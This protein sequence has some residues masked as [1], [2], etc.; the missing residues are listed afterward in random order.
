MYHVIAA[1]HPQGAKNDVAIADYIRDNTP[2]MRERGRDGNPNAT[3]HCYK[4]SKQ[5][6]SLNQPTAH[7]RVS[8]FVVLFARLPTRLTGKSSRSVLSIC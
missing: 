4:V 8:H 3:V 5:L 7:A 6:L 1:T 2:A